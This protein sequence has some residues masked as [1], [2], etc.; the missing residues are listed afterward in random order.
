MIVKGLRLEYALPLFKNIIAIAQRTDRYAFLYV[1]T[2]Y[3]QVVQEALALS[4]F[5]HA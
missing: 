3:Y 1:Y 4:I 2:P 5:V